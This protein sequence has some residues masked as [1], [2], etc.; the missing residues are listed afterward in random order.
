MT[1]GNLFREPANISILPSDTML[2]EVYRYSSQAEST[3]GM[4]FDITTMKKDF[5]AYTLED[6]ANAVKVMHETR[7]P[8]DTYVVELRQVG[9]FHTRYLEKFGPDFHKGMLWIRNVPDFEY[10]LIHCGNDDDDTSGC[11]LLGDSSVQNISKEGFIGDS[12]TA[13][14][15]IYPKIANHLFLGGHVNITYIDAD[16]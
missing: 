9:G 14:K 3:L 12:N 15:R 8:A 2:L 10:V 6:Q 16:S 7:I 1:T 11:L 13:Y 5:L 4:L